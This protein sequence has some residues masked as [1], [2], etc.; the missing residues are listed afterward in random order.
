MP[1]QGG[2]AY[3]QALQKFPKI[4]SQAVNSITMIGTRR[5]TVP[6]LI[7]GENVGMGGKGIELISELVGGLRPAMYHNEGLSF[8]DIPIAEGDAIAGNE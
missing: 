7:V 6:A 5:K 4:H 1:Q 3:I 8:A 2:G